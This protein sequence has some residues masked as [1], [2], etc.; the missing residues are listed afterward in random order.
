MPY[1]AAKSEDRIY[2]IYIYALVTSKHPFAYGHHVY[3]HAT[4]EEGCG[5]ASTV[6]LMPGHN[7]SLRYISQH[8]KASNHHANLPLEMYSF[9]L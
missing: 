2:I 3:V 7:A 8:K 6:R 5:A 9:T 1:N 4:W